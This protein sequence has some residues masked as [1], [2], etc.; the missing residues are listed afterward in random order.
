MSPVL[1]ITHEHPVLVALTLLTVTFSRNGG[2]RGLLNL[3][4]V[5]PSAQVELIKSQALAVPL[6]CGL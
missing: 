6:A 3:F 5:T 1:K 4:R 2:P